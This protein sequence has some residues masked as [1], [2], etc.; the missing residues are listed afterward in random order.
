MQMPWF[1]RHQ[2]RAWEAMFDRAHEHAERHH[3]ARHHGES[4]P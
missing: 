2:A 1:S 3:E 4:S